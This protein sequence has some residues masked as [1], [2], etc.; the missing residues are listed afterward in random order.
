MQKMTSLLLLLLFAAAIPCRLNASQ[1]QTTFFSVSPMRTVPAIDGNIQKDEWKDAAKIPGGGILIDS[2]RIE[3]WCGYDMKHLYIAVKSE[4]PPG[5][6]LVGKAK[7]GSDIVHDDSIELVIV[8]PEN[9]PAGS[10]QHGYFQLFINPEGFSW[11]QHLEPGWGLSKDEWKPEIIRAQSF[12]KGSWNLEVAIPLNQMGWETMPLPSQWH[13]IAA[14]NFQY[15]HHQAAITPAM[16]FNDKSTMAVMNCQP[17]LPAV[18]LTYPDEKSLTVELTNPGPRSIAY[19]IRGRYSPDQSWEA[20]GQL[21]AGKTALFS[22]QKK[23]PE[24]KYQSQV[25]V[26]AGDNLVFRRYADFAPPPAR[27]WTNLESSLVFAAP[28]GTEIPNGKSIEY[29]DRKP[30]IPGAIFFK[31][32]PLTQLNGDRKR[33]FLNTIFSPHGYFFLYE[34]AEHLLL[35]FQYFPWQKDKNT[36]AIHYRK[37]PEGLPGTQSVIINLEKDR[38]EW[39]LN[40]IRVGEIEFNGMMTAENLNGLRLGTSSLEN[41]F[42][43]LSLQIYD[44]PLTRNE[45]AMMGLGKGGFDGRITYFPSINQLILEAETNPYEL[46]RQP[47]ISLLVT[48]RNQN[49]LKKTDYHLERDFQ[50]ISQGVMRIRQRVELPELKEGEYN[51]CL[52][53]KSGEDGSVGNFLSRTFSV[54]KYPWENNRIGLS[55]K[56]VPPFIPLTVDG[57]D[58]KALL[59]TYTLAG[60]G[61]PEAI[62]G[63]GENILAAPISVSMTAGSRSCAW[64]HAPLRFTAKE[65]DRVAYQVSSANDL[66]NMQVDGEFDYDGMLKLTLGITPVRNNVEIERLSLDIPVRKEIA[67]LFHAAGSGNRSNPAGKIPPGQGR[68]WGARSLPHYSPNFVPYIWVGGAE[69]GICYAADWDKDWVH[70]KKKSEH[71][72]ELIRQPDGTLVIRL[73]LLNNA[74]LKRRHEI[75]LALL[76]TPVKPMPEGWRAWSDNYSNFK[77]PGKRFLQCLYA[78]QYFGAFFYCQS[79]YPSFHDYE[80]IHKMDEARRTGKADEKFLANYLQRIAQAPLREVPYRREGMDKVKIAL[81]CGFNQM[82]GLAGQKPEDTVAY[83]YTCCYESNDLLHEYKTHQDEWEYRRKAHPVKSWRDFAV[84]YDAKMLDAGMDGIYLDNTAMAVKFNWPTGDGYIDEEGNIQ[85]SFGLW[86]MRNYI[87]RLATMF[88]EKGK[89][90]FIYVHDTNSLYLPAFSFAQATMDLEW[91]YND[92]EYQDRYSCDYL[93]AMCAGRQGGFFPACI[94]GIVAPPEKRPWLTRTMLAC[95]LP[96]EIQPTTWISAGTD[97]PTYRKIA[98]IIWDFGKGEPDTRFVGYWE[99]DNPVQPQSGSLIASSYHRKEKIL[100]VAGNYGGDDTIPIK[101]AGTAVK[102][103]N[104]ETGAPL[105][106]KGNQVILPIKKHD[107]ALIEIT[108]Q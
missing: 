47:E 65:P 12:S 51:C 4:L 81:Q 67:D 49:I 42:E 50:R 16:Y 74:V 14:R 33:M 29:P 73:N 66:I 89:E 2:R 72:A 63:N 39:F 56:I 41:N 79:R 3:T 31:F 11:G 108:L 24:N 35:G 82:T 68:V 107:I 34:S 37:P 43:A 75:T 88:V 15:P 103:V 25:E 106:L 22:V 55:R 92:S 87:K 20:P 59:K 69:K 83:F 44:R 90:P 40:G 105:S 32:R 52:R 27:K 76:A 54:R 95:F 78:P 5:G 93:L 17:G 101:I 21:A 8:P 13:L 57:H 53:M 100:I 9:R 94:D 45:I 98:G 102:A 64:R 36:Q 28:S 6:K 18:Q 58:V 70:S 48:D 10:L 77:I 46:P 26:Y 85:P 1:Q 30:C 7:I 61:F 23:G 84:Y 38:A 96:H 60:N 71:A 80:V 99:K 62:A 86:R 97:L 19:T 91:K 104:A